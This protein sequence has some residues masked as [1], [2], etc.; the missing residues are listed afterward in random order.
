M[1]LT[2]SSA[3]P[4]FGVNR[5]INQSVFCNI[6]AKGPGPSSIRYGFWHGLSQWQLQFYCSRDMVEVGLT[7]L[8][9]RI[10]LI[11]CRYI[12]NSTVHLY[13]LFS[14][15]RNVD[16]SHTQVCQINHSHKIHKTTRDIKYNW[17]NF[18]V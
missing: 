10:D 1:Y 5:F 14:Q 2:S 13:Q 12:S 15:E 17:I 3:V 7:Q 16:S 6:G 9:L 18:M 4:I 11:Q 8:W